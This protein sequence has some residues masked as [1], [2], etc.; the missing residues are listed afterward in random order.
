MGVLI[1]RDIYEPEESAIS[2]RPPL[3][4]LKKQSGGSTFLLGDNSQRGLS[5]WALKGTRAHF[6]KHPTNPTLSLAKNIRIRI[7][8]T[9][10]TPVVICTCVYDQVELFYHFSKI[11]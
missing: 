4:P 6:E 3:V 5:A 7:E 8:F 9:A 1:L 11:V 10:N 2:C